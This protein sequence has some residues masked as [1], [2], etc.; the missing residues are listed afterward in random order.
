MYLSVLPA[1][2]HVHFC[3]NMLA[4]C[5]V[6]VC[7]ALLG[8]GR[9]Q[10]ECNPFACRKR[11]AVA[12]R[13]EDDDSEFSLSDEEAASDVNGKAPSDSAS[14]D[15][16]SE[17][18]DDPLGEYDDADDDLYEQRRHKYIRGGLLR[19]SDASV[20]MHVLCQQSSMQHVW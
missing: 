4:V 9:G 19:Y 13:G 20:L 6:P 7:E 8:T 11:H 12:K 16:D 2:C 15:T 1:V 18:S 14:F 17:L 5:I 10:T 3:S